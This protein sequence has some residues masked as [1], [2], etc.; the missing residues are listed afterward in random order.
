MKQK[1]LTIVFL[2][3]F[4]L[5]ACNILP[6]QQAAQMGLKSVEVVPS[7]VPLSQ[8]VKFQDNFEQDVSKA[9]GMKVISGIEKQ[10]VI[11]QPNGHLRIQLNPGNNTNFV[12]FN[13]ERNYSDVVVQGEVQYLA[14]TDA[15]VAV[16]CRASSKGWY[17]FRINGQGYYELVKFDQQVQDQGKN[18]YSDLI[19]GQF[20]TPLIKSGTEKNTFALSCV[21][22][23]LK[24]F[25]NGEQ[26][27]LQKR[28]LVVEDQ[29]YT[30]GTVGFGVDGKGQSAD[31]NLNYIETLN[32]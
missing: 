22:K 17:E 3:A 23:E 27:Y 15:S 18:G 14:P 21:G 13:K 19:G 32:S 25:L 2:A 6:N 29:S 30:D 1:M 31:L 26:I 10:I 8:N 5:A 9:W 20:R 16:M 28:P 12:F 4:L 11:T 24:V 7:S